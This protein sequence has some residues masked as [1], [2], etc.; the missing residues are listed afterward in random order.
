VVGLTR[1]TPRGLLL[2][3]ILSVGVVLVAAS[4]LVAVGQTT[5]PG[6]D[7]AQEPIPQLQ[8]PDSAQ[9]I[10]VRVFFDSPTDVEVI[11]TGVNDWPASGRAG[12]PPLINVEVL[13]DVGG[14]L[15]AYNAWHPL[16]VENGR[17]GDDGEDPDDPQRG[18]V[19]EQ[20][21]EGVFIFPFYPN[22]GMV[23][24]SDIQLGQM[25]VEVDAHQVVLDYCTANRD[26]AACDGVPGLCVADVN[27]DG[28]LNLLDA[29][30]LARALW[31]RPGDSRWNS[32]A[33]LNG[34]GVVNWDDF[35]ILLQS[36]HD[37]ACQ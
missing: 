7:P 19:V 28:T 30:A 15:E 35:W 9:S 8:V 13:D 22:V 10:F 1:I 4:T 34:D 31:S 2:L 21:G 26:D 16:W 23:E 18:F 29:F 27:G 5:G 32:A 25:L 3:A 17:D 37:P 11:E 24:I 6:D 12:G 20:S 14:L 33:D 36:F